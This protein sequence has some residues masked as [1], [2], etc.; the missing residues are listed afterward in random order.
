[1]FI[2]KCLSMSA[3]SNHNEGLMTLHELVSSLETDG[4]VLLDY[5]RKVEENRLYSCYAIS[6]PATQEE[7]EKMIQADVVI[8]KL[9]V[10]N[11]YNFF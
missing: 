9:P 8:I 11:S 1:M 3:I 10:I 2:T 6:T 5:T 7:L 4:L